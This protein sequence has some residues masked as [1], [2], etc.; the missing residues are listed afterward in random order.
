M[1]VNVSISQTSL[2]ENKRKLRKYDPSYLAFGFTN[3]D[4]CPQCVVCSEV[5]ANSAM[6]PAKLKRHLETK[7]PQYQNKP[8]D[9]FKRKENE[10]KSQKTVMQYTSLGTEN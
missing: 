5:L 2:S 4:D 3:I 6:A 10:L 1:N 7:H 9:F 8:K